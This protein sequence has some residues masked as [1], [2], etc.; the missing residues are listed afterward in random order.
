MARKPPKEE[1]R[2]ILASDHR[3]RYGARLRF[4]VIDER[5]LGTLANVTLLFQDGTFGRLRKEG[6]DSWELGVPF[7][8]D[9]SAYPSAAE[10][11]TAGQRAAQ[12]LLLTALSF[13][14][15]LRLEYSNHQ[16]ATV[17]DR[18]VSIGMVGG[19][20][21][22]ATWPEEAIA[23]QMSNDFNEPI[24]ARR[25]LLSMELLASSS[26]EAN[27]RTRFVTAVSALEPLAEIQDLGPD[28]ADFVG[29]ALALLRS[30]PRVEGG[31][32]SSLEGRLQ[33][34]KR[35]SVRQS[36]RRLS[37]TWFPHDPSAPAYIDYVYGLRSE[38]LHEGTISD[39]D[40]LLGPETR[41]V[42][43]Y[44]RQIYE[45]EFKRKFRATTAV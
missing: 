28:V 1:R 39:L 19:G 36:L 29:S 41:K 16:P 21:M 18:T 6:E 38:M 17:I 37:A 35:E 44:L 14:F 22:F 12:A 3:R 45:Q 7:E 8:L 15:G 43:Q 26:L 40:V 24:R 9:L 5:Y 20:R 33:Q 13:D 23:A 11:E 31:L 10:A 34:L 25:I 4:R 30:D 2:I 42:R 27:D 32:R